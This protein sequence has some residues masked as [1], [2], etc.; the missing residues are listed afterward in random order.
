[1]MRESEEN[2]TVKGESSDDEGEEE[3]VQY[4]APGLPRKDPTGGEKVER[5][6]R[7]AGDDVEVGG[8]RLRKGGGGR[9]Y[10]YRGGDYYEF[11]AR[12]PS[13]R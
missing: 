5:G 3:E 13:I 1:M 2:V 8:E 4:R 9:R 11:I 12:S 7:G 10:D 6:D